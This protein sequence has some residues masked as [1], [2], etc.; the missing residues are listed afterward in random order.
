MSH[1]SF[2]Y[3]GEDYHTS[4]Y[5]RLCP[6]NMSLFPILKHYHVARDETQMSHSFLLLKYF[7]FRSIDVQVCVCVSYSTYSTLSTLV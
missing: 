4:V 5:E 6:V 2:S 3:H 1:S 7:F